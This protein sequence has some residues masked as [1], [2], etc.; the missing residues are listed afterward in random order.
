MDVQCLEYSAQDCH[1]PGE[2][3]PAL[4][5]QPFEIDLVDIACIDHGRL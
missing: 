1:A 5:R 3:R 2:Y 4:F